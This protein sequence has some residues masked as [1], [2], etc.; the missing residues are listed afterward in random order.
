MLFNNPSKGNGNCVLYLI[1]L[2]IFKRIFK[3]VSVQKKR[4]HL[5]SPNS[6]KYK[7]LNIPK[8]I[9]RTKRDKST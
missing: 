9:I 6:S 5:E 7:N 4:R 1:E 3:A 2:G 8:N